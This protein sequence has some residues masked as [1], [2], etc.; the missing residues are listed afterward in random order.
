MKIWRCPKC[1][2]GVRAPARM[3]RDNALRYCLTCSG[4]TG[5]LVERVCP[6]AAAERT[7][8]EAERKAAEVRA[9]DRAVAKANNYAT[10]ERGRLEAL[11]R[12]WLK[13]DAFKDG[14]NGRRVT[15]QIRLSGERTRKWMERY[16]AP[17]KPDG[18]P[19][20]VTYT[21][22]TQTYARPKWSSGHAWC[23]RAH[24]CVTAGTDYAEAASV[25]LHE[26]AHLA[27]PKD[28]GHGPAWRACFADAVQEVTGERPANTGDR[29][30]YHKVCAEVVR[31]WMSTNMP[32]ETPTPALSSEAS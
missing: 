28:R 19:G 17:M 18:L 2:D 32:C 5:K 21:E 12:D 10:T 29:I 16:E 25:I 23:G 6:S 15:F 20:D 27:T 31:R 26:I 3:R 9:K 13:L 30:E 8:R 11:A 7:R 24:F 14:L 4:K 1:N 22:R